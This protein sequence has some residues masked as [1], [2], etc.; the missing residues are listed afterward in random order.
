MNAGKSIA[1]C[2]GAT[3]GCGCLITILSL[4]GIVILV[5]AMGVSG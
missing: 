5:A 1:G 4:V 2:G 3:M